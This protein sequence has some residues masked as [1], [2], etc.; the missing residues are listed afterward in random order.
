MT[1][2]R[3]CQ[4]EPAIR[5]TILAVGRLD[6]KSDNTGI[7]GEV[8][9]LKHFASFRLFGKS[10]FYMQR[11]SYEIRSTCFSTLLYHF[12]G[13]EADIEESSICSGLKKL[14]EWSSQHAVIELSDEDAFDKIEL[15]VLEDAD[16]RNARKHATL[17]DHGHDSVSRM[18]DQFRDV[19]EA[20]EILEVILSRSMHWLASSM[21]MLDFG[22]SPRDRKRGKMFMN[23][24]E[25]AEEQASTVEEY[26]RWETACR[27]LL[28]E[29]RSMKLIMREEYT[30]LLTLRL[31]WLSGFLA[32]ASN[33]MSGNFKHIRLRSDMKELVDIA[34]TLL[35]QSPASQS[36][37]P[38]LE[39]SDTA[40]GIWWGR[41]ANYVDFDVR[42]I[43]S[44]MSLAWIYRHRTLRKIA[45]ALLLAEP[46]R[47]GGYE[48]VLLGKMMAWLNALE[49]VGLNDDE[50]FVPQDR[51]AKMVKFALDAESRTAELS[52]LLHVNGDLIR[53]EAVISW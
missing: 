1:L 29:C 32:C 31:L 44:L 24:D 6:L 5:D 18:T 49:D 12:S 34:Q 15:S 33:A 40:G 7:A 16:M 38:V 30:E 21:H 27:P 43:I 52:C 22:D 17:R 36:S 25:K 28:E 53:K 50:A 46:S 8:G 26:R 2:E 23:L 19:A 45:I 3:A 9:T 41:Q 39:D 51:A 11:G 48:G 47:D 10:F 20:R 35:Q 37:S 42:S 14:R 4:D 13:M